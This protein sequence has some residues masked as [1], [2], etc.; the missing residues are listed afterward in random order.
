MYINE[1]RGSA[2]NTPLHNAATTSH[3]EIAR[4]LVEVGA[5][6]IHETTPDGRLNY[7]VGYEVANVNAR[8]EIEAT[9]LMFAAGSNR[10][11]MMLY[12]MDHGALC[13]CS[14]TCVLQT[15]SGTG[16]TYDM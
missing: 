6:P 9:P 2:F 11:E 10:T 8:N 5:A 15:L 13:M 7:R 4:L 16:C 12:L 3:L 1:Q 14:S